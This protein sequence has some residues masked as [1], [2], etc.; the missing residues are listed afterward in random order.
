MKRTYRKTL[1]F[2]LA[3]AIMIL[4]GCGTVEPAG[5]TAGE[6]V[7]PEAEI[8]D[9]ALREE[10]P[11]QTEE[12]LTPGD[13]ISGFRVT[14]LSES[15][16]LQ[17]E[18][19]GFTHEKS[20]AEL[21]WIKNGDPELA[22]SINYHTPYIDETDANHVFEH[23]ILAS[24]D[25]YPSNNLLFDL[26]GKSYSTYINAYTYDTFTTYPVSSESEEQLIGLMDA[27]LSCMAAP[28]IL[29]DE[30]IFRREAI[31]YEL[32]SPEDEIRMIGTVFS[33]DF[34]NLTDVW[35]EAENSMADA[36][37]PGQ[38]ASNI[39]GRAHRNYQSLT[40][41]AT[42]DTY[43]RYYHFDNSLILLYGDMDCE[44]ILD[45][46]DKE[47]LSKAERQN[48]D[49]SLYT[50]PVTEEGYEEKTV[51]VPAYEGDQL[52]N[53][54][55]ID[56]AFS[57][58]DNSWED[59]MAWIT[60]SDVLNHENSSFHTNLRAQG[61]QNQTAVVLNLFNAKPY[62]QFSLY[63]GEPEQS[64]T[65]KAVVDETLAQI[66]EEGVNEEILRS[67]LKQTE[68]S[69]YLC[70]DE[71]NVG[72]NMFPDI[73]NFWTHTGRYDYYN[74]FEQTLHELEADSGQE[75]FRRL[76]T[77][78]RHAGRSALVNNVPKPGLAEEI[79]AEQDAWLSDMKASMSEEEIIQMIRDTEEF[80]EW[81]ETEDSN[82]D[83]V[84]DPSDIPDEEPYT[85]YEK[86]VGDGV[87]YYMAPAEVKN[88]G[89][90]Q[91]YFDLSEFTAEEHM[92]LG[93]YCI[94]AGDM[95]TGEHTMEEILNLESEYLYSYE[96][97]GFWPDGEGAYP[98][99]SVMFT[100]LTED[101]E[102]GLALLMEILGSTDFSDT[103]RI[104]EILAREADYYD[105]SRSDDMLAVALDLAAS[106]SYRSYA[107][108]EDY[109]RQE[110]YDYLEEVKDKLEQDESYGD[111]LEAR[112]KNVS[113][114]MMKRG[115]LVFACAAP[116]SDIDRIKSVS[117]SFLEALPFEETEE[118]LLT[119]PQRAQK[120]AVVVESSDQCTV[121]AGNCYEV[122]GFSGKYVPFL[123][124]AS[125]R[126]LVPKIRFQM[127]AYS[128][129]GD[130]RAYEGLMILYSVNDPN[131]AATIDVFEKTTDAIENLE[132]TEED[133][134]GYI[135]A[136]VAIS[137]GNRG[138]LERPIS[139]MENEILGR[140]NRKICDVIND[141]K[142]A[143]L[144]DQKAAAECFREIL[145]HAGTAT[146]GNETKLKADQDAYDQLLSYKAGD[147]L[148][149]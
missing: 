103:E 142:N 19:I 134:D 63:Y 59:L 27:Y 30:N 41:E 29:K 89:R 1:A 84:I 40:Y 96:I 99:M 100:T 71:S 115:R 28:G 9:P 45:F 118:S 43:R 127:G 145:K 22:F 122:D 138:V 98:M 73:I 126:Y 4:N 50:D 119:L 32:D 78:A 48:T 15:E 62:I 87:T 108:Y 70:R 55:E 8:T 26:V 102:A 11:E 85:D 110:F 144:E 106:Y 6:T 42:L 143:S 95:G 31:R 86:I 37:Y 82:S 146:L 124:A 33:E 131:A 14:S 139:A 47:Y 109:I 104:E 18:M 112:L 79:I 94:L 148:Q 132:L 67:V 7:E 120:R 75:I 114:K 121:T 68:T 20:G 44:R 10:I 136:A 2:V 53:A 52:E 93:I 56:Y 25:K 35:R 130:F 116:E 125:D 107:Y 97:G 77:E 51:F 129:G 83:F 49:L 23:A 147:V 140:D 128:C 69:N 58:E 74:V 24:S 5:G 113:E 137:H 3:V 61:I 92:D 149:R 76:A 111:V 88:V 39:P 81:N 60:L 46:I 34:G 16:M 36:L 80:R 13:I 141:M 21:L 57:L 64:Q 54:S 105:V 123:M 90:Y 38:Y 133:L 12:G 91:I 101:Y 117:A 135:L 66:E 72:V 65:F 17:A